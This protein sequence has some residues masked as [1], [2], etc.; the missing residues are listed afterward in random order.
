MYVIRP[1]HLVPV[2]ARLCQ[3][4]IRR[5]VS[6]TRENMLNYLSDLMEDANDVSWHGAKVVHAVLMCDMDRGGLSPGMILPVLIEL[7][8]L[9]PKNMFKIS[10]TLAKMV[11]WLTR[12]HGFVNC[13]SQV[14]LQKT[15]RAVVNY[16]DISVPIV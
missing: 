6:K 7:G 5:K 10:K 8:G 13:T 11:R 14:Y 12:G 4:Y 9:T 3:K 1:A 16:T 2:G 15:M